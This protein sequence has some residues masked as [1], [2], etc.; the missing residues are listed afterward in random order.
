[1]SKTK[2]SGI[3]HYELLYLISNKF[4]EEEIK[5]IGARVNAAITDGGG[6]ITLSRELGKKRLAYPIKGFNLGYYNLTEFDLTG[7]KLAS[8]DRFLR[9]MSEVLRHQ[10]I[11]KPAVTAE[12]LDQDRKIAE[13]IAARGSKQEQQ[14]KEKVKARSKDKVDLKELDEKL[15]KILETDDLL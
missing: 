8:F 4:S 7:E 6:K 3:P 1:M 11:V 14:A 15:D 2:S 10:I 9:L 13:K 12:Q 5:P